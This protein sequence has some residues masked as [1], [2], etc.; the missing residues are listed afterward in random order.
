MFT[1]I[2]NA[3]GHGTNC[4]CI[5]PENGTVPIAQ[6]NNLM[7]AG[8]VL[9]YLNGAPLSN[10]EFDLVEK[11]LTRAEKDATDGENGLHNSSDLRGD[12]YS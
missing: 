9:R 2:K 8:F 1:I 6:A 5:V 4:F 7:L 12:N 10:R 11:L 3:D